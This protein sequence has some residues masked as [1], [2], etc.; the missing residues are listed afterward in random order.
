MSRLS[1]QYLGRKLRSPIVASSSPATGSLETVRALV[2][3]GVGAVVLPSLFEEAV[4]HEARQVE[5]MLE[6]TAWSHPEAP[7]G[8]FPGLG[9]DPV[10]GPSHYLAQL[11]ATVEAVDVPVIASLNGVTRG[12]WLTYA[13]QLEE[14]GAAA[15][16]LNAYRL[17]ASVDDDPRDVEDELVDL[18][19][20]V[21]LAVQVPV[22]VKL[23]PAW[24]A[25]GHLVHRLATAGAE[26]LVLFNRFYQPDIDIDNRA[27]TPHLELSTPQEQLLPLR[28]TAILHGRVDASLAITTGVH[29]AAGVAKA[30]LAGADVAMMASAVLRHGP[31]HVRTVLMDLSAWMD[32]HS[33]V[34]VEQLKGS[35]SQ[36][37]VPDPDAFERANYLQT[38]ASWAG[39]ARRAGLYAT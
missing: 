24:T 9:T 36:Q 20:D 26:G 2:D 6:L 35:A 10:G 30:L 16:E 3:A 21:V 27:V 29:D 23:S 7:D 19:R 14:A 13:V 4:L 15:I 22:A 32:E 37:A 17:A 31:E 18:V 5:A 39:P 33:Y 28:W 12:G 25:L 1:T 8:Y 38:L 34:S 11:E